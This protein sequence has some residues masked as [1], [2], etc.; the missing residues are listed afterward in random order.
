MGHAKIAGTSYSSSVT[1]TLT[2][3]STAS[4]SE[5]LIGAMR[6]YN[7]DNTVVVGQPTFGKGVFQNA[8][9]MLFDKQS[10]K[11]YAYYISIVTGYYYIV[12]ESAE[13]GRYCIHQN[14]MEPDLA[15][16]ANDI[17]RDLSSDSEIIAAN[18]SFLASLN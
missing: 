16:N 17:M 11:T 6:A 8:P 5:A 4:A 12:D 2:N 10:G 7:P 15:V 14:P 1:S 3:S 9:F 13:G 18:N